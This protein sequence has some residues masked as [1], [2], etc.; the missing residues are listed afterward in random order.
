LLRKNEDNI[1]NYYFNQRRFN[2]KKIE[3]IQKYI[4]LDGLRISSQP[5]G[6]MIGKKGN[7]LLAFR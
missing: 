2:G 5:V 7:E 3:L 6:K 1:N 4:L